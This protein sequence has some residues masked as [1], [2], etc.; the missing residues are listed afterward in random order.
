M[1]LS[2]PPIFSFVIVNF[3]VFFLVSF[4]DVILVFLTG[5]DQ[6]GGKKFDAIFSSFALHH[7]EDITKM[8]SIL[9]EYLNPG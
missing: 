1:Y 3:P 2:H 8:I 4:F 9:S 7:V 6:L 5:G